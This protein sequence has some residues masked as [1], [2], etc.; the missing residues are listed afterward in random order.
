MNNKPAPKAP[1]ATPAPGRKPA[2]KATASAKKP[3]PARKQP[4]KVVM[5]GADAELRGGYARF[6]DMHNARPVLAYKGKVAATESEEL[7]FLAARILD[8]LDMPVPWGYSGFDP[9]QRDDVPLPSKVNFGPRKQ[10]ANEVENALLNALI[11][12]HF[13]RIARD[14]VKLRALY[15]AA[16][17]DIETRMWYR[18]MLGEMA[19]LATAMPGAH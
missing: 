18:C 19:R 5:V 16:Q 3:A 15:V 9:Y 2:P 13:R 11:T 8:D 14:P 12:I 4:Q 7:G 6:C 10:P 17:N 1:K